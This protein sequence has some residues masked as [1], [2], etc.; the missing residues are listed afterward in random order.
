MFQSSCCLYIIFCSCGWTVLELGEG[1]ASPSK[2]S[3]PGNLSRNVYQ[4]IHSGR[5]MN[6]PMSAFMKSRVVILIFA[7]LP[8]LSILNFIVSQPLHSKLPPGLL[9]LNSLSIVANILICLT[10][11]GSC[12]PHVPVASWCC[13]CPA[14]LFPYLELYSHTELPRVCRKTQC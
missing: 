8:S 1:D 13:R 4:R 3:F 9:S 12:H 6:K 11:L 14:V 10:V 5:S 7:F 2:T